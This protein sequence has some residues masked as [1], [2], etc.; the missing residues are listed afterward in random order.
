MDTWT[1]STNELMRMAERQVPGSVAVRVG[2]IT[3]GLRAPVE[4][5]LPGGAYQVVVVRP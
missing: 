4:V 1:M 3:S 5:R 2:M